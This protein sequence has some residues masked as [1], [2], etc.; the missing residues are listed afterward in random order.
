MTA[1]VLAQRRTRAAFGKIVINEARLAW[2]QPAGLI[3]G[4]GL[5]VLLLLIFGVIPAFRQASP[6]FG[7]Y[8]PFDIYIPILISFTIGML[9]MFYVPGPLVA[10]REQG[11]LRRLSA[12]PA[13]PSWVLAAQLVVQSCLMTAGILILIITSIAAF[14]V[15]APVN[16]AG[17]VLSLAAGIAAMFSLGLAIAAVART[18]GAARGIMAAVFYPLNFF[19]GLYVPLELF[20]RTVQD[21][22]HY[23]PLGAVVESVG[24]AWAGNFHPVGSLLALVGYAVVFALIALRYFRWE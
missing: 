4:I 23:T 17:V 19:A 15:S 13:R 3:A 12:T 8:S 7:G 2:R 18:S 16:L 9:G 5:P 22:G 10:Y 24:N 11:I 1:G 21:I 14:G 20:P 6:K